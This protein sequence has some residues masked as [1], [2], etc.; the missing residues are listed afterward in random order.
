M[1][2]ILRQLDVNRVEQFPLK[3]GQRHG[4]Q[5]RRPAR[6]TRPAAPSSNEANWPDKGIQGI[7][8]IPGLLLVDKRKPLSSC[9]LHRQASEPETESG[10][11]GRHGQWIRSLHTAHEVL[12]LR[13]SRGRFLARSSASS[14]L[15]RSVQR[16]R[17]IN[18]RVH[19]S[20]V[21]LTNSA[22]AA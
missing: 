14:G 1:I 10:S 3:Q 22:D 9:C 18:Q 16:V 5:L 15:R 7:P 17:I 20:V 2:R 11:R 8:L 12:S 4:E 19:V 6:R 13:F 21:L